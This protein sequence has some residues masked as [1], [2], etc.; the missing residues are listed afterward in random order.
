MAK[1]KYPLRIVECPVCSG[2]GKYSDG[3]TCLVCRGT[4]KY[5]DRGPNTATRTIPGSQKEREVI[6][7]PYEIHFGP[8]TLLMSPAFHVNDVEGHIIEVSPYK[9]DGLVNLQTFMMTRDENNTKVFERNFFVLDHEET[10]L[11]I[12]ALIEARDRF[13]GK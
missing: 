12:D 5:K 6:H 2:L 1:K 3:E 9:T 7:R 8:A 11:L 13:G 4:G 10:T